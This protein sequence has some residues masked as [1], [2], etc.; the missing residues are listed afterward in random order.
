MS[1]SQGYVSLSCPG[2][3]DLGVLLPHLAGVIVE[4]VAVAA[5]AAARHGQGACP[6]GRVPEVRDGV[7]PGPQPLL[8]DAGR[9]RGWRPSGGVRLA[10][11]RFLCRAPGCER[12]IFAEQ[13]EGPDRP[14]RA[15]DPAARGRAREDRGRAG[16]AGGL[17]AG[18]RPGRPGEQAGHAEAGHGDPGPAGGTPTGGRGRRLRD[19]AGSAVRHAADRLRDRRPA[20]PHRGPRRPSRSPTGWQPTPK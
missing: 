16:G 11:R 5:R 17:S 15:E 8:Q 4:E 9:C 20:G 13:V 3:V 10:V 14:L 6:R 2:S 12:K 19:P 7:A 1:L 18:R